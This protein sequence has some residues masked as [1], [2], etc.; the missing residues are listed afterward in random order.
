[1]SKPK[2]PNLRVQKYGGSSLDSV[3]KVKAVA[4]QISEARQQGDRF[5]IV[6]SA[7]GGATDDLMNLAQGIS[8]NPDQR[9]LDMLL[10]AGERISVSLMA[11][12]LNS[13]NVPAISFTGSQAGILTDGV[14]GDASII[15][16]KP[17]RVVKELK[18]DKVVV[19]AG[20]QGVSPDTKDVTTLGRGG[21]DTTAIAM[22]SHFECAS[23][24]FQKDTEGIF[25]QD[26]HAF[27]NAEHIPK[28]TWDQI[29]QLTE[30][31]SPFLHHKAA[32]LARDRRMP[33]VLGHAHRPDGL[34]TYVGP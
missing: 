12:A 32:L 21:S 25:S 26:P 7:M 17:V 34:K 23:C 6:V 30:S 1:M 31:G 18:K 27:P 10:T 14:H 15:E 16:V 13:L 24:E 28:M 9:E 8:P 19:I 20:F 11:L 4:K 3:T 29:V 22:A 2:I 5:L 33:L